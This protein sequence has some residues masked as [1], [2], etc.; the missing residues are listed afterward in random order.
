MEII[1][2]PV[3]LVRNSPFDVKDICNLIA[4]YCDEEALLKLSSVSPIFLLRLLMYI[5]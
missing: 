1:N 4:D 5:Y 2:Q 3:A